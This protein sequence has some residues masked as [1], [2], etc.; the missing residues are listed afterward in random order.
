MMDSVAND[1]QSERRDEASMNVEPERG[2]YPRSSYGQIPGAELPGMIY[3]LILAAYGGLLLIAWLAFGRSEESEFNISFA[4][5]LGLI[6]FALPII[7]RQVAARRSRK[8][9]V[10]VALTKKVDIATGPLSLREVYV[11]VLLIPFTLAAAA[12]MIGMVDVLVR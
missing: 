12:V 6:F 1:L 8:R 5:A 7:L 9:T 10:D 2:A 4:V 11:Q 3:Q